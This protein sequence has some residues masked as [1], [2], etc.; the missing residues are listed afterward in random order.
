MKHRL[1]S[2]SFKFN[3]CPAEI[4]QKAQLGLATFQFVQQLCFM[5]GL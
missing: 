3:F 4:E 2:R 1:K 5:R